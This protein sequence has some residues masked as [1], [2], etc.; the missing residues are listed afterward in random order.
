MNRHFD[1][2]TIV[3]V[4]LLG[5]SLGL[6]LKSRGMAGIVRGVGHRA[7]SLEIAKTVGAI[8]EA[9]LDVAEAAR[10]ADLVV[11]STPAAMVPRM[12]DDVR[13][14]CDARAV[15]TDV[16]STKVEVCDHA[17]KTWPKPQRF[18]GS[19]PMAGS[20]KYGPEHADADLYQGHVVIVETGDHLDNE[21]RHAVLDLWSGVG[22]RIVELDPHAHDAVVARTSHIPHIL[23][24]CAARLAMQEN[25][26]NRASVPHLIGQG[27]RDVTRIAASRPEIWRDI[28]LTNREAILEGLD[29][30][31]EELSAVRDSIADREAEVLELYFRAGQE[32]RREAMGE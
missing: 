15:V 5:G 11:L 14:A 20:E 8:D 21:A 12:L 3:G 9:F 26:P 19:H 10:G 4:G 23:A 18:V 22:A 32:A 30:M 16:A 13:G 7:A 1:I 24:A 29:D 2:V 31:I 17:K 28:C 27:F 6:A 25:N